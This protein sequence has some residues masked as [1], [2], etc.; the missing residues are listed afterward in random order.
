MDK[1]STDRMETKEKTIKVV[2][3]KFKNGE[4]IAL[5]SEIP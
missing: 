1:N 4:I 5:F 2:F 3:R